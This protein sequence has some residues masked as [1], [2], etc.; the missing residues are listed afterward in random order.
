M[1]RSEHSAAGLG[2]HSLCDTCRDITQDTALTLRH[3]GVSYWRSALARALAR[4]QPNHITTAPADN[5][6][7]CQ[8]ARADSCVRRSTSKR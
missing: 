1:N 7:F 4:A 2:A 3:L 6:V 5:F 8:R